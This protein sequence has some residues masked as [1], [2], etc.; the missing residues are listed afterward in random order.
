MTGFILTF[1]PEN[2]GLNNGKSNLY[3]ILTN[4]LTIRVYRQW[5]PL[6]ASCQ[7]PVVV[8]QGFARLRHAVSV[9]HKI[10]SRES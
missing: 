10:E 4:I 8:L 6:L 7:F 1:E 3:Q 9:F 5:L 2:I